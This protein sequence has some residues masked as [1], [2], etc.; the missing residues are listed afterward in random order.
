MLQIELE[1]DF[2]IQPKPRGLQSG[3]TGHI[4]HNSKPY[5]LFNERFS[6]AVLNQLGRFEPKYDR[7]FFLGWFYGFHDKGANPDMDNLSGSIMDASK[8]CQLI[9][10]DNR[11]LWKGSYMLNQPIKDRHYS[12]VVICDFIDRKGAIDRIDDLYSQYFI[13]SLQLS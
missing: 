5:S 8:K 4:Y 3:K 11:R 12:Y 6:K 2:Y 7:P 9:K 13:Q 10:D 1:L